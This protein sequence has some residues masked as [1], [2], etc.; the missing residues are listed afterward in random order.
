MSALITHTIRRI[1]KHHL[2]E[3]PRQIKI[4]AGDHL[5]AIAVINRDSIVGII[6]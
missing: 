5:A 3:I 6:R 1:G 2:D 4:G